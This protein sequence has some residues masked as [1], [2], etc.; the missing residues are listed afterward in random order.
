VSSLTHEETL[1]AEL[2]E[3]LAAE[4]ARLAETLERAVG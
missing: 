3:R 1:L 2:A 4:V